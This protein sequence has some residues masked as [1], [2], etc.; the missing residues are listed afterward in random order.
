[1][2]RRRADW[3]AGAILAMLLAGCATDRNLGAVQRDCSTSSTTLDE[4]DCA[5]RELEAARWRDSPIADLIG[6][7]L[8]YADAV[9]ERVRAGKASDSDAR[10][11]LHVMMQRVR[12]EAESRYPYSLFW[13]WPA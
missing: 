9:A 8:D 11:D 12:G 10:Q 3:L 5:R 13:L 1:M 4:I 7:Y 6:F 2:L